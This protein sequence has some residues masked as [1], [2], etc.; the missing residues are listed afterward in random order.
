MYS[1]I[2]KFT[3]I[4]IINTVVFITITFII[5][6]LSSYLNYRTAFIFIIIYLICQRDWVAPK[7]I[8]YARVLPTTQIQYNTN[9]ELS[10]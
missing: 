9:T 6:I 5:S 8:A 10:T 1:S 7:C 4:T 2:Q 3:I